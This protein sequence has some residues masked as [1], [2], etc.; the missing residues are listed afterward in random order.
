[1]DDGVRITQWTC[2][3]GTNQQWRLQDTGGRLQLIARHSNKCLTIQGAGTADGARAVQMTCG[4]GADQQ[5][6]RQ[7]V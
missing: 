1:M 5:W 6:L 2:H 3:T 7:A 4:T